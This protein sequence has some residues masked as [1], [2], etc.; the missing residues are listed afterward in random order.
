MPKEIDDILNEL[1]GNQQDDV[2]RSDKE[3][4]D[5]IK[6]DLQMLTTGSNKEVRKNIMDEDY[7]NI[8]IKSNPM[9]IYGS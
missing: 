1:F 5:A 9:R 8:S 3:H 7:E 6:N 4:L 2:S